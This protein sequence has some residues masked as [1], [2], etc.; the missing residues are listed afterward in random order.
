MPLNS[1]AI[2]AK[3]NADYVPFASRRSTVHSSNGIVACTQPLAAAA[4]HRILTQG[5]NAAVCHLTPRLM[6]PISLMY[7]LSRQDAAVAVGK[8]GPSQTRK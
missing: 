1:K 3:A 4:G 2:Y 7:F 5:G 8:L 6:R